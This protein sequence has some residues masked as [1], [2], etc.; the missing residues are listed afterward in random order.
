MGT[1]MCWAGQLAG[2]RLSLR[3]R[4]RVR[5]EP[6]PAQLPLCGGWRRPAAA[7]WWPRAD[8]ASASGRRPWQVAARRWQ[9]QR[10]RA[11][12]GGRMAP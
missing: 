5:A 3:L 11:E 2:R 10:Q 9:W 6:V 12:A 1:G 7:R 4:L 8:A